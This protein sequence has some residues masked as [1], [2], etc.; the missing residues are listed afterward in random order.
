MSVSHSLA[1]LKKNT[2]NEFDDLRNQAEKLTT[3]FAKD[4]RFWTLSKDDHGNG[5]AVIRFLPKPPGEDN[6]YIRTWSY[7]FQGANGIWYIET[8][9]QTIEK[10]DPVAKL[11]NKLFRSGLEADKDLA[12][13]MKRRLQFISNILVVN[14]RANPENNGK[15]FLFKYGQKIWERLDA[16][17]KPEFE[18]KVP[19]NPFNPWT[20]VNFRIRVK[21]NAGG[22][23]NY[24]D[25]EFDPPS[26]IAKTDAEIEKIWKSCYSLKELLD[27]KNFKSYEELETRLNQ[28]LSLDNDP[29]LNP[30][31][32]SSPPK[33]PEAHSHT[34]A[35]ESA[36]WAEDSDEDL[37]RFRLAIENDD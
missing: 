34:H 9:L 19:V 24:D 13:K 2:K 18:D 21:K 29:F 4:D 30:G 32:A 27:E 17:T 37:E 5:S 31:K 6:D 15:V 16:L 1:E 8:S 33:I 3:K 23:P 36:P 25:S 28:V 14:D 10:D 7:G 26:P 11:R 20:G 35:G 22:F 12:S